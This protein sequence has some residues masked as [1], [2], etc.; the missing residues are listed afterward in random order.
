VFQRSPLDSL[1]TGAKAARRAIARAQPWPDRLARGGYIGKGALFLLVGGLA[2]AAALGWGGGETT[3]PSGA[4]VTVA[5][6]PAGRL[7]LA[8]AT[9]AL[10]AHAAFRA[11]LVLVGEPYEQ[12]GRLWRWWR[13]IVNAVSAVFYAYISFKAGALALGA[14]AHVDTDNDHEAR[15][16]SARLLSAPYGRWLLI[17]VAGAILV[18]AVVQV[19]RAFSPNTARRR[20][21][22]EEMNHRQRLLVSVVGRLALLARGTILASIGYFLA[23]AAARWSPRFARGA[24]GALHAVWEQPHGNWLL[25]LVAVGLLALG[26]FGLLEARWRRL[27]RR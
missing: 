15:H 12:R 18:A 24:A 21:R 17:G 25:G 7:I 4:L 14:G 22:I 5:R 3:D 2:A 27:F 1:A 26:A 20:L 11:A 9:V 16:W 23:K 8:V 10:L 19:V 13:R 6:A